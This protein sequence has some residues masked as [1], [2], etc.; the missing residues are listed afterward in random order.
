M[1]S[2]TRSASKAVLRILRVDFA[3]KLVDVV[4]PL[5][6]AANRALLLG[7][8]SFQKP[9]ITTARKAT[10]ETTAATESQLK[11]LSRHLALFAQ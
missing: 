4:Q 1:F 7:P 10:A 8:G 6:V 3:G 9:R 2:E 5:L 11:R